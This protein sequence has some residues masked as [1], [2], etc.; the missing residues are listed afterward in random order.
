[1]LAAQQNREPLE[2]GSHRRAT[3]TELKARRLISE[4]G[5]IVV[6][7]LIAFVLDAWWERQQLASDIRDELVNVTAEVLSNLETL[8]LEIF[9]QRRAVSSIDELV[10]AIDAAGGAS[11]LVVTDTIVL[12]AFLFN[13]S[14]DPSTGA[15]DA[16]IS[17]G[18]LSRLDEPVLRRILTEFRTAVED[19]RED[20][21]IARQISNEVIVPL[22]WEDPVLREVL[23]MVS[24]YSRRGL[25]VVAL[26]S[27]EV[28]LTNLP[29]LVNQLLMR[30]AWVLSALRELD[31]LL[32]DLQEAERRL[33][34]RTVS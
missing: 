1:M 3:L 21:L 26:P 34:V 2:S 23:P 7:I 18:M 30:R 5:V 9:L 6:S 14:Y 29:G 24:G 15:V 32:V 12:A 13:P 33:R 10:A 8:R 19:V 4:G 16:L 27:R 22:L 17:S 31:R 20:E 25:E 11:S 28:E